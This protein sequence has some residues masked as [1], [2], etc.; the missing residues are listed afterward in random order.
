[1]ASV[2]PA[3]AA[4]VRAAFGH[5][6][7]HAGGL[8]ARVAQF[9]DVSL[10]HVQDILDFLLADLLEL[11]LLSGYVVGVSDFGCGDFSQQLFL[12]SLQVL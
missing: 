5:P 6:Q 3:P 7:A 11:R 10:V 9:G 4:A 1:M 8:Q 12:F 2:S